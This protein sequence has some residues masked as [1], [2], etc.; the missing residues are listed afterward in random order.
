VSSPPAAWSDVLA[1]CL[2]SPDQLRSYAEE[3]VK[4]EREEAAKACDALSEANL[5]VRNMDAAQTA[6]D[7]AAAIRSRALQQ[8]D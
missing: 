4:Q 1:C 2:Y 6:F 3:A 7:C 5:S 8:G